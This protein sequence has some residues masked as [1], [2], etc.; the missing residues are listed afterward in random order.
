MGRINDYL[1]GETVE[2]TIDNVISYCYHFGPDNYSNKIN[3]YLGTFGLYECISQI[4]LDRKIKK[5]TSKFDEI[6]DTGKT[7]R[8]GKGT[9]TFIPVLT[10]ILKGD[11]AAFIPEQDRY[12][13][14]TPTRKKIAIRA[15]EYLFVLK[16]L[17]TLVIR[18]IGKTRIL[19]N[20]T[21][22]P[23]QYLLKPA[24]KAEYKK[25]TG[26]TINKNKLADITS[27]LA[28]FELLEKEQ[29]ETHRIYKTTGYK[30][31]KNSSYKLIAKKKLVKS[32]D[33]L[34]MTLEEY[35]NLKNRRNNDD[36]DMSN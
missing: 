30:L 25:L 11:I 6:D 29:V 19:E 14:E 4:D 31:G 10:F 7:I 22:V 23:N 24:V 3:E 13:H 8:K 32:Q 15:S 28:K 16:R 35:R 17:T 1:M 9:K 12:Q 36:K 26:R 2:K 34:G 20:P 5:Y 21:Q 27:H 18:D 33:V